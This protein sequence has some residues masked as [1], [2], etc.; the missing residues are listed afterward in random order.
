VILLGRQPRPQ[1][2]IGGFPGHPLT[3]PKNRD[4]SLK[5]TQPFT[6]GSHPLY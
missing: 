5:G 3:I 2:R 4:A 1:L 6:K